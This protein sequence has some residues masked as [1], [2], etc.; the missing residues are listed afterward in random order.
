MG[1]SRCKWPAVALFS[2]AVQ[3]MSPALSQDLTVV[4]YQEYPGSN[5]HLVNWVMVE[6]GFCE[7]EG[8]RCEPILLANGPLA[9]KA[10]AAGS[11]DL[12][13][14]SL[15][16]MLQAVANGSDLMAVGTFATNN[17]YSFAV[18]S[19]LEK[20]GAGYP[21]NIAGL[22]GMKIGVSARGSGVEMYAKDLLS[23]AGIAPNEVTFV[24]VGAAATTYAALAAG[25]I[26]AAVTWDPVP[27]MCGATGK[28][29]IAVDLRKGEGP[30]DLA[31]MNGGFV[32]WQARREYV[33]KN[34]KA[35]D[36]F[37]RAQ[38]RATKWMREPT[39]F[40]EAS[41]IATRHFKLTDDV[42]N[43]DIVM[44]EMVKGSISQIGNHFDRKAIPAFN[45]FL[46]KNDVLKTPVDPDSI[47]YQNAP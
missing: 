12:I 21:Q 33:A 2:L 32:A 6:K 7:K 29:S 31:A 44:A 45:K 46:I 28:C 27:A 47:I 4:R 17:V 20:P 41:A 11:V 42:P 39:N 18:R 30:A 34:P 26:D 35:I 1:S 5:L 43:R 37:L 14:S 22:K 36:A 25:Q 16:V 13:L 40:N 38:A 19:G 15:D 10:V 9:Q 8:L 23:G 24:A 3:S